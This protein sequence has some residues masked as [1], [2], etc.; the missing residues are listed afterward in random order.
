MCRFDSDILEGQYWRSTFPR[1][2]RRFQLGLSYLLLACLVWAVYFPATATPHWYIFLSCSLAL[3][4]TVFC[5]FLV[6]C[7]PLYTHNCFKVSLLLCF[8][9]CSLSLAAFLPER[10]AD[11]SQAGLFALYL[12]VHKIKNYSK[13]TLAL[14]NPINIC[15]LHSSHSTCSP[16]FRCCCWST[17]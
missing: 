5:M 4:T 15:S 12:Q 2:T 11:L 1:T 14:E 17:L 3:G 9:L 13:M 6:T 10:A 8:L 7:S 16:V